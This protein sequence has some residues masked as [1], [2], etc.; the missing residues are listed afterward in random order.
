MVIDE[1]LSTKLNV[2]FLKVC[3]CD[4][5]VPLRVILILAKK[6][7]PEYFTNNLS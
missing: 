3:A 5:F 2:K 1:S 6:K 4:M 7:T